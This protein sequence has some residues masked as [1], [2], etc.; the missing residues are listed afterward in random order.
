VG[1]V[2]A[3]DD[4]MKKFGVTI[5]CPPGDG[6]WRG[7]A[8]VA[9]GI[10]Y[11]LGQISRT[12]ST[13]GR[14]EIFFNAHRLAPNKKIPDDAIIFNAEQVQ[15]T[16]FGSSYI[17]RLKHHVVWDYSQTNIDRLRALGVERTVLCRVGYYP[18][19]PLPVVDQDID[20]LFFGSM[21]E[22][23]AMLLYDLSTKGLKVE[24]LFGVYGDE[25]DKVLARSKVVVNAHFYD[26][27]IFEI[28]RVAH[29]LNHAKCVVT[30]NGGCDPEL[31]KL[32]SFTCASVPYSQLVDE[33][34]YFVN[35][36]PERAFYGERGR[37]RFK[38]LDQTAEVSAALDAT[39]DHSA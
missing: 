8:E 38:G 14:R 10:D 15:D 19:K 13:P 37:D 1:A 32:A 20:V 36:A 35:R 3:V 18:V 25:R 9:N 16:W 34:E 33:C 27:P 7:L 12:A 2:Q 4:V 6:H 23:R 22:R 17:E 31:E 5:I 21:N 24:S 39:D 26:K 11:S 29:L 28:F 30:E